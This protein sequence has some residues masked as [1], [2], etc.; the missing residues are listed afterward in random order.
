MFPSAFRAGKLQQTTSTCCSSITYPCLSVRALLRP[1]WGCFSLV[2]LLEVLQGA[3][4]SGGQDFRAVSTHPI[5]ISHGWG[6]WALPALPLVPHLP[7]CKGRDVGLKQVPRWGCPGCVL[8]LLFALLVFNEH[9]PNAQSASR[10]K[11]RRKEEA[12]AEYK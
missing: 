6:L 9:V 7:T 8:P 11:S 10:R 5:A 4:A 1:F 3:G 2:G 12:H